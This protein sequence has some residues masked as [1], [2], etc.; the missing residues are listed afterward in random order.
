VL[1]LHGFGL[2]IPVAIPRSYQLPISPY[3]GSWP[4]TGQIGEM[5]TTGQLGFVNTT[6]LLRTLAS[7]PPSVNGGQLGFDWRVCDQNCAAFKR[8]Y[9]DESK[10]RCTADAF[11]NISTPT[12]VITK[13]RSVE[14]RTTGTIWAERPQNS[15]LNPSRLLVELDVDR[16]TYPGKLGSRCHDL[17]VR[18][19]DTRVAMEVLGPSGDW[20]V[21]DVRIC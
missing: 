11:F 21:A 6:P 4:T 3:L 10:M 14:E 9:T 20:V 1:E 15:Q 2:R 5:P 7:R 19:H 13:L 12:P 17:E 8:I 18:Y 16:Q